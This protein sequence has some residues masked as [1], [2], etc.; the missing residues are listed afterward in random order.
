MEGAPFALAAVVILTV[1]VYGLMKHGTHFFGLF[2]PSGVPVWLL[3]FIG[4]AIGD[5]FDKRFIAFACMGM[6]ALAL[7]LVA[8]AQALVASDA[9][10]SGSAQL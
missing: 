10:G 9:D 5:K 7:M 4:A 6:H 3:P 8:Y 2:V 1:I